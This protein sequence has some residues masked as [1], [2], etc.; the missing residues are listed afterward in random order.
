VDVGEPVVADCRAAECAEL[1]EAALD[2]AA[3][4]AELFWTLP[5]A[6]GGARDDFPAPAGSEAA[7]G[8][9]FA[10]PLVGA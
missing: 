6:P 1:S 10:A 5:A 7:L 3:M 4:V 9:R 8:R 2:D